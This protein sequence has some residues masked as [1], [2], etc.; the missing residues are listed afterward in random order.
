MTMRPVPNH[1]K[2]ARSWLLLGG[3]ISLWTMASIFVPGSDFGLPG[4]WLPSCPFRTAAGIPCP[5]CGITTGCAW[6]ARGQWRQAWDSNVLSPVLMIGALAFGV[7][8]VAFRLSAG[9]AVVWDGD[10]GTRRLLWFG[11]LGLVAVSWGFN[12]FRAS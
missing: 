7:Y 9:L 5:F 1:L 11:I 10:T 8:V 6:L 12:L 2:D 4:S 3:V